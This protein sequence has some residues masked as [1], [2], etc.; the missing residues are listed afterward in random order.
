MLDDCS[1]TLRESIRCSNE[2]YRVM[3]IWAKSPKSHESTR[4]CHVVAL[5][6][7][8]A[9][10]KLLECLKNTP[11]SDTVPKK[12]ETA[13]GYKLLLT[14]DIKLLSESLV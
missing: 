10:D 5:A 1:E 14:A 4:R 9:L 6:Y 13:L 3:K 8:K 11:P 7:E 2:H 12:L